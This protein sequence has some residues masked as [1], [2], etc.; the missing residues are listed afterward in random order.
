MDPYLLAFLA[1]FCGWA[2][3][4]LWVLLDRARYD[5]LLASLRTGSTRHRLRWRTLARLVSESSS[6]PELTEAL[7]RHVLET[8][9]QKIVAAASEDRAAWRRIE[10]VRILALADH[11]Q[12]LPLLERMLADGDEEVSAAA[13]TI[14]AENRNEQATSVLV[15]ALHSGTCPARWASA[16]LERRTVPPQLLAPLLDDPRADVRAAATRL[17]G[18][19][20]AAGTQIDAVLVGLC[21]DPEAEVR[22]AAARALGDRGSRSAVRRLEPM[23]AD[24]VWFVQVRAARALGQLGGVESGGSIAGLLSSPTWWVRQAAKEAL[25]GLGPSVAPQLLPVLDHPD[26]FARNSCAEVLQNLGVVDRLVATANGNSRAAEVAVATEQLRK[27]VRAG[28]PRVEESVLAKAG[29]A[30]RA[31]LAG[32]AEEGPRQEVRA[33]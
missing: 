16:L 22:A 11:P 15:D 29:P 3:L 14:L 18:T 5:R 25:V 32:A 23:L 1:V 31:H 4:S 21:D 19:S 13:A 30:L 6:D 17:L 28:G 9:E 24:R 8:N 10:A 27:I 7:V 12:S 2:A 33:A 26:A 20:G